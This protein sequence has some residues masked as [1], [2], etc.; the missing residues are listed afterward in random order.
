M[1]VNRL[2]IV[3]QRTRMAASRKSLQIRRNPSPLPANH[4]IFRT[5]T[6]TWVALEDSCSL[7]AHLVAFITL[8]INSRY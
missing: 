7:L 1:T 2:L 5:L 4:R 3:K 8:S 6:L